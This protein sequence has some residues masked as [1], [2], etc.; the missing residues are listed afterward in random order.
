MVNLGSRTPL[1]A[2]NLDRDGWQ[3]IGERLVALNLWAFAH[4]LSELLELLAVEEVRAGRRQVMDSSAIPN[5][6]K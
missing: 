4:V 1:S 3:E 5:S 2:V 6:G